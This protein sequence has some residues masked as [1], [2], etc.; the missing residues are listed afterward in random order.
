MATVNIRD[1]NVRGSAKKALIDMH[2]DAKWS[3]FEALLNAMTA[4]R[5]MGKGQQ[6][7]YLTQDA[8]NTHDEIVED[9][10]EGISNEV[11][12]Y[13][14]GNM[15]YDIDEEYLK[16]QKDPEFL[17]K[18]G[19]GMN[20][21]ADM[22]KDGVLEFYSVSID[23]HGRENGLIARYMIDR[24]TGSSGFVVPAERPSHTYVLQRKPDEVQTGVR[25][26]IKNAKQVKNLSQFIAEKFARKITQ[27]YKIFYRKNEYE[28]FEQ[29]NAPNDFC[30]K[31]EE[32]AGEI[33]GVP[34]Y[35]DLHSVDKKDDVKVGV[36]V[37]KVRMGEYLSKHLMKGYAGCDLLEIVVNREGIK[38]DESNEI[39]QSFTQIVD[40]Y[41]EQQG[42]E[43]IPPP[44]VKDIKN[45]KKWIQKAQEMVQKYYRRFPNDTL[46]QLDAVIKPSELTGDPNA[47]P[48]K[49]KRPHTHKNCQKGY[50]WDA[51]LQ[52]CVPTVV[53]DGTTMPRKPQ[54]PRTGNGKPTKLSDADQ[55]S[56]P[57]LHVKR[58]PKGRDKWYL[59][60][61]EKTSTLWHNID[62]NWINNI[63]EK[64]SDETMDILITIAIMKAV[65][66]N[67]DMSADSL[68]KKLGDILDGN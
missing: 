18:M 4:M 53:D 20:G 47:K 26:I 57:N 64:A 14:E 24:K 59:V 54:K 15:G 6:E 8:G 63:I 46:L 56:T 36:L 40:D 37:K 66:D 49:I 39:Y 32:I 10:G 16:N 1:R 3:I 38:A 7:S 9:I 48:K 31:H 62:R 13:L 61:D 60:L 50:H 22:S 65:P 23:K 11:Y 21:I 27:G 44:N 41:A 58:G 33:D 52:Q 43:L 45:E 67:H 25:L 51:S 17:N 29:L 12:E 42:F 35:V 19:I 30:S 28:A 68:L 55:E 2:T 5:K 34:V